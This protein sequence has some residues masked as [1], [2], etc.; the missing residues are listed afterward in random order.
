MLLV[1]DIAAA[2]EAT[3][4]VSLDTF[5]TLTHIRGTRNEHLA[6][7]EGFDS[8]TRN[9][10]ERTTPLPLDAEVHGRFLTFDYCG[11]G[12]WAV[13]QDHESLKDV[14]KSILS[15]SGILNVFTEVVL[16]FVD[17]KHR[18]FEVRDA[19]GRLLAK[20]GTHAVD[21]NELHAADAAKCRVV[22]T[23]G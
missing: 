20:D 12:T 8:P 3:G 18:S 11:H 21:R 23:G 7:P 4:W 10:H 6:D 9:V 19:S 5:R 1:R 15:G 13:L 14:E 2:A 17:G 22:W 16:A